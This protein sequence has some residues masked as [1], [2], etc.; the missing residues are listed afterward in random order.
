VRRADGEARVVG[1]RRAFLWATFGRYVAMA[2][3][4][5]VTI[6]AARLVLPSSFGVSVLS[7][8]AY[9]IAEAIREIG[10]GAYLIQERELTAEKIRSSIT[11]SLIVSL[12]LATLLFLGARF[13]AR[14]YGVPEIEHYLHVAA[15][16]FVLGP[17]VFPALALMGR[18][19]AFGYQALTA[20]SMSLAGG[21]TT[22]GLA[23]CGF[24]YMAFAW[25][26]V[27]AALV[28]SALCFLFRPDLSLY[29]WSLSEWRSVVRFGLFDSATSLLAALGEHAPY[30]LL[31]SFLNTAGVGIAQRAL[32]L[33]TFPE[34]VIL[35][36][37]GAVALPAFA[38]RVREGT[39]IRASYLHAT[40]MITAV[41]WP[42]LML[43]A[44]LATP[45]VLFLLGPRWAEVAPLLRMLCLAMGFSFPWALQYPV[46][47][48][49][50]AVRL[51]PWL[52]AAQ[53]LA[54]LIA[55]GLTAPYGLHA[56]SWGLVVT[57]PL[58]A[59]AA[60]MV[61]RAYLKFSSLEFLRAL[62]KSAV[63]TAVAALG[64]AA[65]LLW[66]GGLD[67]ISLAGGLIVTILAG[68]GW[69]LGL[70]VARHPLREE[71]LRMPQLVQRV[72]SKG[73]QPA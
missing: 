35:A 8:A 25:A 1:V 12:A 27:A 16:G 73:R 34:R 45:L 37:V 59:L 54:N 44:T 65:V 72:I 70:Y 66:Q 33:S 48:A 49:L 38:R 6:I 19:L 7:A 52:V 11:V 26:N 69:L 15:L 63:V 60:V 55:V 36:G 50:G 39:D 53:A 2:I 29:R 13:I 42:C 18:E 10:G 17:F 46:L 3:N 64:P 61:A 58:N 51:L 68:L 71:L 57:L 23:V 47:V 31:G 40:E 20:I 21:L 67:S 32:L 28:G 62:I 43:L 41:Q 56:V 14:F 9:A 22:I 4:L 30:L 5:S 24:S